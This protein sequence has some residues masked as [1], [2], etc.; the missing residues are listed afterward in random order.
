MEGKITIS[1]PSYGSGKKKIAISVKDVKSVNKFLE[2]EMDYADFAEALTGLS[3]V[4]IS[5]ETRGLENVGKMRV[6]E[7]RSVVVPQSY[8]RGHIQKYLVDNRQEEGW[9]LNTYLGSQNSVQ[10]LQGTNTVQVNYTVM[11]YE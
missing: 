10:F 11:R 6:V 8:S 9:L 3:E 4:P 2:I 5:F 7:R 1:R